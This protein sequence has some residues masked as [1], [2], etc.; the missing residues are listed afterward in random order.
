MWPG[1]FCNMKNELL[2]FWFNP[3][4]NQYWFKS[5]AEIDQEIRDRFE[6]LWESAGRGEQD[7]WKDTAEGC[8]AL[9]IVLDQLPLN[10]FRGSAKA[11]STE[12]QSIQL[13]RYAIDNALDEQLANDRVAFLYLPLMHSEK[14]ED[15]DLS[16]RMFEKAGLEKNLR[17]AKHHRELIREFGRF[18]HRNQ[19]LGRENTPEEVDYLNSGRAFRG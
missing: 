4:M 1:K 18:P 19:L 3:P 8:L 5:T 11:F 15:Q 7:H 2:D 6:W 17:F 16:V 13:A 10:M 12:S 14:L 9:C